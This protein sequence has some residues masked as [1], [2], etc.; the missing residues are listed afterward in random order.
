MGNPT[1][2]GKKEEVEDRKQTNDVVLKK[3]KKDGVN[4]VEVVYEPHKD[5]VRR[6]QPEPGD[7]VL[8]F[9][10]PTCCYYFSTVDSFDQATMLYE[11]T[12]DDQDPTGRTI[13]DNKIALDQT[14]MLC[15][16]G[17]NEP[18]LFPQ[19]SYN[20]GDNIEGGGERYHEGI[21]TKISI[22]KKE[23][24]LN[25]EVSDSE[26]EEVFVAG[27]HLS[28]P[29]MKFGDFSWEWK[30]TMSVL[31]VPPTTFGTGVLTKRAR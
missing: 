13:K 6:L 5:M 18:V 3:I 2:K 1:S 23:K 10:E 28:E 21:I 8:T 9:H 19:G 22:L 27:R 16:L 12:W 24:F 25:L 29:K 14:P 26:I 4:Y 15:E 30:M 7:H 17:V 31:K 11:V 20:G